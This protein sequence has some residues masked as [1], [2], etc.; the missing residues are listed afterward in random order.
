M[1]LKDYMTKEESV[2]IITKFAQMIT[3]LE[4]V[5][6]TCRYFT[7]KL[8]TI[9]KRLSW[10]EKKLQDVENNQIINYEVV[11]DGS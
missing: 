8:D 2:M 6:N 11:S 7:G 10:I 9:D 4:D 5:A 3:R 1:T